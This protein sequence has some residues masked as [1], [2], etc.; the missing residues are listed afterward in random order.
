MGNCEGYGLP[1]HRKE[2]DGDIVPR[3]CFFPTSQA[4]PQ[5]VKRWCRRGMYLIN[6]YPPV[7]R[8][9]KDDIF[10][11]RSGVQVRAVI[12][13]ENVLNSVVKLLKIQPYCCPTSFWNVKEKD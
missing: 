13:G 1:E 6:Q 5:L 11:F 7:Y 12:L 9:M 8:A 4:I 3:R 2:K 10:D